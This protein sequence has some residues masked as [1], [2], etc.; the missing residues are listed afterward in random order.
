MLS[1]HVVIVLS[2][3]V[4]M[5]CCHVVLS[6]RVVMSCCHVML[7]C[8]HVMLF[9]FLSCYRSKKTNCRCEP[10]VWSYNWQ[11]V[12]WGRMMAYL[13]D[14]LL[15]TSMAGLLIAILVS[16]WMC[17]FCSTFLCPF[18]SSRLACLWQSWH[19]VRKRCMEQSR[20]S[21]LYGAAQTDPGEQRKS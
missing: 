13:R 3:C 6:C 10:Q 8:C 14:K 12:F 18:S 19:G 21:H 16:R 5:S 2:C 17:R 7:S 15:N 1:S 4:V 11:S 9:H 20:P